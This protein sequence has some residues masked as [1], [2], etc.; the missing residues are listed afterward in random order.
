[1][2][3]KFLVTETEEKRILTSTKLLTP[4]S[5]KFECTLSASEVLKFSKEIV[6]LPHQLRR[7]RLGL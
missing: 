4:E 6:K 7:V 3:I 2:Q 1:M 5:F